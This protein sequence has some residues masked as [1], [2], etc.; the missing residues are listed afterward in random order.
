MKTLL[1]P[2]LFASALG[3]AAEGGWASLPG[4][5]D[6][7]SVLRFEDSEGKVSIAPFELMTQPVTNAQFLAFVT[8]HPQWRR[9]AAPPAAPRQ[10][11][12]SVL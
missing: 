5:A 9:G 3:H 11:A 6:F 2:L 8:T 12:A 10:N 1:L 4:S 7:A